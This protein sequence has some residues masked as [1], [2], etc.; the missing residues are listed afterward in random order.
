MPAVVTCGVHSRAVSLD[1]NLATAIIAGAVA[2]VAAGVAAWASLAA[3][4]LQQRVWQLEKTE[5]RQIELIK[6]VAPYREPLARAAY[7]LQSRIFT[8]V[9]SDYFGPS[10]AAA[11]AREQAYRLQN[12]AFLFAQLFAWMEITRREIQFIDLGNDL[13]T[14]TLAHR[15]DSLHSQLHI[16][17]LGSTFRIFP[18]E[19]RG[20]G[21]RMIAGKRPALECIGYGTFLNRIAAPS[22][23]P[24]LALLQSEVASLAAS[25]APARPRLVA[26]QNSLIDLLQ[27]LDPKFLRFPAKSRTKIK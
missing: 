13:D 1:E 15:Q 26:V 20:I 25:P 10:M 9:T 19:Q 24:L 22:V 14:R 6:T 4:R 21:E 11:S 17:A 5:Q 7:D 8:V 3:V 18:G 2:L 16:E 27:V 23:D 12:T